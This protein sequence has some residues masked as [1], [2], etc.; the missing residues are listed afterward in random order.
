VNTE[1]SRHDDR[2][3]AAPRFKVAMKARIIGHQHTA[4]R[5]RIPKRR[6]PLPSK[7]GTR[8]DC[9]P[10]EPRTAPGATPGTDP[11]GCQSQSSSAEGSLPLGRPRRSILASWAVVR[12]APRQQ[13]ALNEGGTGATGQTGAQV[14]T[15]FELKEAAHTVRINVVGNR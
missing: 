9:P 8:Q 3:S 15:V 4:R 13:D 5:L 1:N 11:R 10:G 7:G 14:N 12:A 2:L 6:T